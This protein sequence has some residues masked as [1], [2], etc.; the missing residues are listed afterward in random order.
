MKET[1]DKIKEG[2]LQVD[3][4]TDAMTVVF[5]K[6]KGGYAR[7]V[8]GG[9][10]YKMHFDLP[11]NRQASDERV[12]LLQCQL[13]N[14]RRE[15]EEKEAVIKNLFDQVSLVDINAKDSN[16]DQKGE[17]PLSV[18]RISHKSTQEYALIE[19][20]RNAT[21][22]PSSP[23]PALHLFTRPL[24]LGSDSPCVLD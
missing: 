10:K 6:E 1:E 4:G 20:G 9:M 18:V 7:G 2:T 11:L 15:R 16:T 22:K 5:G 14:E 24:F 23:A 13:D 17:A 21:S 8:G 19:G 3:Q 12:A